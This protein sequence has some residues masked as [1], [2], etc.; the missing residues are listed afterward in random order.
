[1]VK[2]TAGILRS[3]IHRVVSAPGE[4]GN[5]TRMSLVYFARPENEVLMKVL[6]GS[7]SID[8]KRRE[9][10]EFK[11]EEEVTAE[12]WILRRAFGRR[13]GGDFNGSDG[14]EG[15]RVKG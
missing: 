12:T 15:D 8:A 1:M 4:Q 3:N 7:E 14:T 10:V 2:F 6:E 13:V 11:G 5:M 9:T